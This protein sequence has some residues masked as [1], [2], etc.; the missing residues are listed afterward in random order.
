MADRGEHCC[1]TY[2]EAGTCS[3]RWKK[4]NRS[5]EKLGPIRYAYAYDEG[6]DD[7]LKYESL[8]PI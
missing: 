7:I 2:R 5:L 3:T 6:L 4:N 8:Q 1:I